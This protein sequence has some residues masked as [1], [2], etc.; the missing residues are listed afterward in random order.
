MP[1][2][3]LPSGRWQAKYL[4]PE[5]PHTDDGTRNYLTAPL[6]FRTKTEA[7]EWLTGIQADIAR[8]T[9]KSPEQLEAA[10][11]AAEA[12]ALR[13]ART[14]GNYAETWLPSRKLT[15][16]TRREYG[17]LLRVHLRPRWAD[18]PLRAITTP[19]V[20]AW[21]AT[22][23]PGSP[24]A[25]RH[26]YELFKTIMAT[27]VDDDLLTANPCKR[28]MLATV[29]PAPLPADQ[30]PRRARAPRALTANQLDT[31]TAELP[32]YMRTMAL[33]A[34]TIGLRSGELRALRGADLTT[35]DQGAAWLTITKAV[36][37]Q[38]KNLS[39]GTP[40]THASIRTVKVPPSLTTELAALADRAGPAGLLF[41]AKDKP[42]SV[43]PT[44]TWQKNLG[45]A[46]ERAG[47]GHVS[48]HDLRHTA[49]TRAIESGAAP[50]AVRDMLG[51]TTT[52]MTDRY[53]HTSPEAMARLVDAIDRQRTE[54]ATVIP[55]NRKRNA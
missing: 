11:L 8:G 31:L 45:A 27:A 17:S 41:H 46:G 30:T 42:G 20:R 36:S 47:I 51:H 49:S 43:V 6:T 7:R 23:A 12:E 37:G 29:E 2:R 52:K 3:G 18:V 53:T 38:G 39:T 28:N 4:H 54:P 24:G 22:L 40:K 5:R 21:L 44:R 14:F 34:G 32:D 48:P 35:D 19:D 13:A 26:A 10:R 25:R 1:I 9:W 55:I 33:L 50:A 15:P 16:S